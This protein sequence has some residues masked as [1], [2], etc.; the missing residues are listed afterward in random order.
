M[1]DKILFVDH[2]REAL[3]GFVQ[4]LGPDYQ[5]EL[6]ESAEQALELL[7]AHGP[8]GVVVSEH[9]A[10][11]VSLEIDLS[12]LIPPRQEGLTIA[13]CCGSPFSRHGMVA[14]YIPR[15]SPELNLSHSTH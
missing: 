13:S 6:A 2:Q 10:Q 15:D 12:E 5:V 14:L 7:G 1:K 11:W 3:D 8:F 9:Q 4:N